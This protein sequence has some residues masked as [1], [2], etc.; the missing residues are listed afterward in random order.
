MRK[1]NYVPICRSEMKAYTFQF[2]RLFAETDKNEDKCI[3]K[4]E[5]E[6]LVLDIISTGKVKID[7]KFA[8]SQVMQTFDFDDSRSITEQEFLKG[9]EKWIEETKRSSETSDSA[10]STNIFHE[11]T[12]FSGIF[13]LEY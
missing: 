5:L 1:N 11:V 6:N 7:D 3:T 8:V 4:R 10:P 9:C 12:R 13:M 2:C